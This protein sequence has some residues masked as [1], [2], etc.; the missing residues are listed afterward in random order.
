MK[1][2]LLVALL[3]IV[4]ACARTPAR[5]PLSVEINRLQSHIEFLAS[6]SL[7]GRDTGTR[8]YQIAAEYVATEFHKLGLEPGG[9]DGSFYQSVPMSERRLVKGSAVAE[10]ETATGRIV[11]DYP[12]Q[13]TMGPD[14][15]NPERAVTADAVFVG[16]GIVAPDFEHDDYAGLD[17]EGK[18]AVMLNGRPKHW[19]TEEGAHLSSGTRL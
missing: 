17:V 7:R 8:G 4:V 3:A 14:W 18:I 19:P 6:D 15:H 10:L 5:E 16:Y 13:F 1:N 2:L 12:A 9:D 11:L